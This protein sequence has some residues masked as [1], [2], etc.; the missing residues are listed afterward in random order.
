M[1]AFP[2][3]G[4]AMSTEGGWQW[5]AQTTAAVNFLLGLGLFLSPW[6]LGYKSEGSATLSA[7]VGNIIAVMA[8]AALFA[9]PCLGESSI[10]VL[11]AGNCDHGRQP[12][13]VQAI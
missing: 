2:L 10:V 7:P 5:S 13:T 3:M 8:L 11:G 4:L 9:L 1:D 12:S 6:A